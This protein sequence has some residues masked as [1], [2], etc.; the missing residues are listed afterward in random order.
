ML[1]ST[2]WI[3]PLFQRVAMCYND[4]MNPFNS[5][6]KHPQV[7]VLVI[8]IVAAVLAKYGI[9]QG[10]ALLFSAFAA[11]AIYKMFTT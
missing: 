3:A 10:A 4:I 5:K 9:T 1:V 11:I 2:L 7:A 6:I 8:V